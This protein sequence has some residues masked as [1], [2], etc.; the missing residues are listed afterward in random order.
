ME[1]VC[2]VKHHIQTIHRG[3]KPIILVPLPSGGPSILC[4]VAS[5]QHH[6]EPD[7]ID[8][9]WSSISREASFILS[10]LTL[11]SSHIITCL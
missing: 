11:N 10:V 3:G 7:E 9:K 2:G 6:M 5:R 8:E 1:V 4:E